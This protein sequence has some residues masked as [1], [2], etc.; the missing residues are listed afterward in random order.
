MYWLIVCDMD[1]T[2]LGSDAQIPVRNVAAI[3]AAYEQGVKF[4]P[5]TGRAARSLG[6]VLD[7]LGLAMLKDEYVISY[8][9]AAV[10]SNTDLL[11][12]IITNGLSY[13][14]VV[15]LFNLAQSRGLDTHVYTADQLYVWN[16]TAADQN[17]LNQ[18]KVIY[19]EATGTLSFLK[20]TPIMKIIFYL[21]DEQERR[22][23]RRVI[24]ETI[25]EPLNITF[26]SDMYVEVN[27]PG[28]DKG[29][30]AVAL[31]RYLGVKPGEIVAIGDN[32]NDVAM[33]KTAGLGV[34]VAN[35][36]DDVK[37]VADY[38]T[39]A[40]NDAGAVGEVI[41]RFILNDDRHS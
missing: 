8:N 41:E 11:H 20:T 3:K 21:A 7:T 26:S 23:F 34:C 31:G 29:Q 13:T 17:Y 38:V 30:A 4:V 37:Q 16:M 28:A 35:G 6:Y 10:F 40:D 14:T 27:A 25:H 22:T 24:T 15:Q 36:R 5:N 19:E 39:M 1:E 9:G 2:L 32:L 33:L 12:P 18:R